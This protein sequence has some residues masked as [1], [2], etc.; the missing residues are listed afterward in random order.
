MSNIKI[1]TKNDFLPSNIIDA[2]DKDGMRFILIT[3]FD[4]KRRYKN[5]QT[6]EELLDYK[7]P[8]GHSLVD[9]AYHFDNDIL[10]N[11]FGFSTIIKSMKRSFVINPHFQKLNMHVA[12]NEQFQAFRNFY[13]ELGFGIFTKNFNR[14][15]CVISTDDL[16]SVEYF[17]TTI[18]LSGEYKALGDKFRTYSPKLQFIVNRNILQ[19]LLAKYYITLFLEEKFMKNKNPVSKHM[20]TFNKP[21]TFDC[22]KSKQKSGY[23]KHKK[24]GN[25]PDF[26]ISTRN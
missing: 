22:R 23:S 13:Y 15:T 5:F 21:K 6:K 17:L 11:I 8:N 20:E 12:G 19:D 25:N 16:S 9:Y 2:A 3:E 14:K 24:S 4:G 10:S 7:I 1:V 26:F 18:T